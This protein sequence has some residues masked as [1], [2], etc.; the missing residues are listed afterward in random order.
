MQFVHSVRKDFF[1]HLACYAAACGDGFELNAQFVGQ[2]V[3]LLRL[4]PSGSMWLVLCT[5]RFAES[6]EA[7]EAATGMPTSFPYLKWGRR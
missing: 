6:S 7:V 3:Q 2:L 1:L 4:S 5:Y